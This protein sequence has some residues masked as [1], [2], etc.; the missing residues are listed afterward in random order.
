M[1]I[2]VPGDLNVSLKLFG[3]LGIRDV[4]R[5]FTPIAAGL[6]IGNLLLIVAG[7]AA[8]AA[9]C[10]W[11][12]Y[13]RSLDTHLYHAVRWVL[14]RRSVDSGDLGSFETRE[15]QQSIDDG[16][17][18]TDNGT[19][20]A[21]IEVEPTN[22]DLKTEAEQ[23]AIHS[24]YEKLLGTITYP[25]QV[26]TRQKSL[27]LDE[28][29]EDIEQR[30]AEDAV[31]KGDYIKYLR[32]IGEKD[33][34][35]THHYVVIHTDRGEHTLYKILEKHSE[36]FPHLEKVLDRLTSPEELEETAASELERRTR[37]VIQALE[38]N[39]LSTKRLENQE[40]E[41]F[42]QKANARD[43]QVTP[44][45][46]D[47][48]DTY[49]R[50]IVVTGY[51]KSVDLAWPLEVLRIP[52]KT[53]VVQ[54]IEPT[55]SGK[56]AD[57]LQRLSE[58]LNAEIDSLLAGGHTGTNKL[59]SLL[60]DTEWFLDLLA[61]RERQPV[62]YSCYI[63]VHGSSQ[64]ETQNS[65]DKLCNRLTTIGFE[66]SQPVLQTDQAYKTVSPLYRDFL[67][68]SLLMPAS[69]AAA[70]FPF[71]TQNTEETG[72][73]YGVDVY[74]GT[75]ILLDRFRWSSHSMARMGMVGSGKTY[76][77]KIELLRATLIY[78]DLKIIVV[79][80]KKEYRS[81]IRTLEGDIQELE[82][83][84]EYSL[85]NRVTG[86]TVEK[87]GQRENVELLSDA[88]EQIYNTVSQDRQKTLVLIDEA[89][90]LLNDE[91]GRRILNQFVLEGRDTNTA[92]TLITQNASH[93][94]HSREGR[95]I[96]DNM[97][98]KVFMRHDRVPESV[99]DYFELSHREKQELFELNT[100]TDSD[101]SEALLRVSGRINT[102][103]R[104]ESTPQEHALIDSG[105]ET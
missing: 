48:S 52:G 15:F 32:K 44:N 5:L 99:V 90:I 20:A 29:I 18:A 53:N 58:K 4:F 10:F 30:E 54:V 19:L 8:G 46:T 78:D 21:V 102:R 101:Y 6:L 45:W 65:F 28:Y 66:Y 31:L 42:A 33:L 61:D 86:L 7:V 100:G 85:D 34:N 11:K 1:N 64:E 37:E 3:R 40:L 95:E 62:E 88:V 68:H 27:D 47:S 69:S 60:E 103:L 35:R 77:A 41:A 91:D 83:D 59:E 84:A 12:P 43:T 9:W 13:D 38:T 67:Q 26:H 79:D 97:P 98:G 50:S 76:A 96:L 25:I 105:G 55:D 36:T 72:V 93:F 80:P 22:L 57:K 87:R 63:D 16:K 23:A 104:V 75:P 81:I 92:V 94:T 51:P 70:S 71:A 74:D 24:I 17:I 49:R 14:G 82:E 73:V 56:T 89:R 39:E 2:R